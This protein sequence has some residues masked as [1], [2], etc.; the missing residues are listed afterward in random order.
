MA[1]TF[2]SPKLDRFADLISG[3][4]DEAKAMSNRDAAEQM[5]HPRAYGDQLFQKLRFKMGPQ[6]R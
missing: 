6:A 3:G 2:R 1:R 4:D 5:G